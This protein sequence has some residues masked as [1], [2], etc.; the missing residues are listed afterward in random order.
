MIEYNNSRPL[1]I[2]GP[3]GEVLTRESLP[4][5]N[6]RRWVA[7]RKAQVVAAVQSGLITIEEAQ[8][9]YCLSLE[10]FATWQRALDRGGVKAL[11]VACARQRQPGQ[12]LVSERLAELTA[13]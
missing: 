8:A 5:R 12:R 1:R 11:R 6:T 4:P 2:V 10:E 13:H 9:R 3:Q 7:S